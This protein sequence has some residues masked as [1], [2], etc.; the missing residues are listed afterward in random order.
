[1][2]MPVI[3]LLLLFFQQTDH[4]AE[5]IKAL[6]ARNYPA[7]VAAFE[8]L[9]A[10]E[11][12]D[13]SAH[14][15]LALAHSLSGNHAAA[16][17]EYRKTL[18]LK[19]GLY[20]AELN[21]GIVLIELKQ[22]QEAAA[23]LG[24]ACRQKPKEFRPCNYEAS[25]LLAA[26]RYADAEQRLR[27]VLEIDP[28]AAAAHA[29]LGSALARQ[30]KLEAAES[31]FQQAAALDAGWKEALLEVAELYEKAKQA[32]AAIRIYE[33]FPENVAARERL[34]ELLLASGRAQESIPHLEAAVKASPSAANHYA[35]ATAFLRSKQ[36]DK[37]GAQLE[38]ALALEPDNTELRLTYGRVLRDRKNTQAAAQQFWQVAKAKPESK[39]AWSELAG[40][41]LLLE[42]YPQA[43]AAYDRLEALGES[44]AALFFFRAIALDRTKQYKPALANYQRFLALSQDR[45]P[46]EEFKAR[47]RIKVIEKELNRR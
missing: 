5:G 4:Q 14:F 41:L 42:N 15:H 33:Q 38:Q 8:K 18:E 2:D 10:A 1:M 7:A 29:S 22:P 44:N 24:S 3:A 28:K 19:P 43:V 47:Q 46:D 40:M 31:A 12:N 37:A 30:G 27:A 32:P 26:G 35:L 25:A 21:L 6:E 17:P 9:A 13:Y 16:A 20:E 34:A 23:L 11:P 39:E 45:H 36:L